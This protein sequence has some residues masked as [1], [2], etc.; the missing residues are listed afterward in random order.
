MFSQS[1]DEGKSYK[2]LLAGKEFKSNG[3]CFE[4]EDRENYEIYDYDRTLNGFDWG[5]FISFTD[6]A[7][8]TSYSAPCGN[9]CF[10]SISGSYKYVGLN[11]IEVY[12]SYIRRNGFC[13]LESEEPKK[14]IGIY[15]IEQTPTGLKFVKT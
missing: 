2:I 9:D 11:K 1:R 5:Y 8:T 7:F 15:S 3:S 14:V 4:D 12:V 6:T 10:T 13:Q